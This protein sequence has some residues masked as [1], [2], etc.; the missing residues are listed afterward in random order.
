M[1]IDG[2]DNELGLHRGV[3][4]GTRCL[5]RG[6]FT[7]IEVLVVISIIAVLI[8]ILLPTLSKARESARAMV[9]TSRLRAQAQ[10]V[11][12]YALENDE[13]TPPRLV[14][15][16]QQDGRLDRILFNR[17]LADWM[18][19]PFPPESGTP[20]FI[21][22]GI[23]RCPEIRTDQE[24]LRQ[25]HQGRIHH[26]PNQYLFGVLDFGSPEAKPFVSVDKPRGWS[27][28]QDNWG[29]LT[30]PWQPADVV[31]VMDNVRT[32]HAMFKHTD[33]RESFARSIDVVR[34]ASSAEI[35]NTGAHESLGVRL[36]VFVDGHA[37]SLL[38]SSEYWERNPAEYRSPARGKVTTFFDTEIR[39]FMYMVKRSDRVGD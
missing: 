16:T 28:R 31:E 22:Q 1:R 12:S 14:W 8:S 36:A 33:A 3:P 4:I 30:D 38:D 7:L 26:A 35:E 18:G 13:A 9:C 27:T 2:Q 15:I 6:A 24:S 32:Y 11:A 25:T 34:E 10:V 23:W 29:R 37:A 20:L 17:F 21:P 5:S 39:H 19:E